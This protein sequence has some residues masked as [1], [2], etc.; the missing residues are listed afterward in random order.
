MTD[1]SGHQSSVSY[2]DSFSDSLNRNTFAYPTTITDA[3][4]FS[5]TVQYNF[6]FGAIT[7]TQSPAPAGQSQGAIQTM[8]YNSL[9]QLERLTTTNN[10]AYKRF[11]Y[12]ADFVGSYTSVNNVADELYALEVFDGHGRVI[13]AAGNHPG[14]TGGY[15]LVSTIY[16]HL[17]RVKKQSNPTE[18]NSS[19]V[20]SGDDAAGMY[21]TQQTY[22]WQGRPLVTT[23]Q[24]G[25]TKT[26][27][28]SGCG[29]AGGA[30]VTLT[31]E[32]TLDA[33]VVKRR[34]QKIFS[35]V[36]GR[37]VK[38]EILTWQGGSVYSATVNTYN[39]RDQ[40][41]QMRQ[42]AGAEGSG[43]Y[44]D[45]TMTYDG[46]GRLKTK[47][48]PEQNAG[49]NT[50][51]TYNPDDTINTVTDA[52]GAVATYGHNARHLVTAITYSAPAGIT[53]TANVTFSY[54]AAGNRT[55]MTE[56]VGSVTYSH[57]QLSQLTSETR[58]ITGVGN[59]TLNYTYNLIGQLRTI[60]DPFG[61]QVGYSH[62]KVG[63][64]SA[65]TGANFA[66]VT[67]YASNL[68]YRAWGAL[69]SLTYG[70]SK[71]LAVGYYQN[72]NVSTYEIPG[73]MKKAYQYYDDGRLKFTQDQF[74]TNSKFDRLYNYDH[75]GRITTALSGAE[76]RGQ[77]PTNDRPYNQTMAY[78]ALGHL[79]LREI[80]HWDRW[81]SSGNQTYVNNR[82]Q[83]WQYDADGRLLN[84]ESQYTYDA[85]GR[86]SSFGDDDP[87]RTDQQLDGDGRRLK[88][89]QRSFDPNTNQWTIEKV[90]Y[91]IYSSV[92]GSVISE[93]SAAGAKER[94]FVSAG[95]QV[96]A[97]QSVVGGT[98][99][100]SWEHYDASNA[101]YRPTNP[102]GGVGL[103]KEM[104]PIGANA[105]TMKPI[106]WPEPTSSGKLEP[107][108][109]IPELNSA[110][111][112]CEV[113]GVPMDC[114]DAAHLE[115][116]GA[117]KATVVNPIDPSRGGRLRP[118]W[119]RKDTSYATTDLETNTVT[120][121]SGSGGEFVWVEELGAGLE[122]FVQK[123]QRQK[124][125][126]VWFVPLGDLR[127]GLG[128]LLKKKDCAD[129]VQKLLNEAKRLFGGNY[130]SINNIW[131]GF[132][133]ISS[134]GGYQLDGVASN[135]GTVTGD[136]FANGALS[137]T[138]HIT[139]YRTIDRV[140]RAQEISWAQARYA[141]TALHETFHLARQGGYTDEQMTR[142]AYSLAGKDPPN[143]DRDGVLSWS[144]SFDDF[145]AQH[146]PNDTT[147]K[148]R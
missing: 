86:I 124:K 59:F 54:D 125:P 79:T 26:A 71:T 132:D 47:H 99:Y 49:A 118:E 110:Y 129:Y 112:G 10:S 19:W 142:A 133:K 96:L 146:C 77:G 42:Y 40:V 92:L 14:S 73:V 50:V 51:F 109:G 43:T 34:Q 57:N 148:K 121:Y 44:Q 48:V 16:D 13:G 2:A 85:A 140:P 39:V 139:P 78:D 130:D 67:S 128:D 63:R 97:I 120:I 4:G 127:K 56:G 31:D 134:A 28:Y 29:C 18:V 35:D 75:V 1:P 65:V 61:A 111:D 138:V 12:G 64:L 89:V 106:T 52:R 55:S 115:K 25:T 32:G 141:Y 83:F 6:D 95:D 11:W 87:Y 33:G 7:R 53:P 17:G 5:S 36:F 104:D 88:S 9:G 82:R 62:D 15:R 27:A 8:T 93:V 22:D 68:Q 136:L 101:S 126:A 21:Y 41:T 37:T 135:G 98:Q 30:V 81:D 72:L 144:G 119:A 145:L 103:A 74:T 113:N 137:G 90:T 84:G 45:T 24:D 100:V 80:R 20:P 123:R 108:Y 143:Y 58:A 116:I 69:K 3:G 114:N 131:E 117:G 91:Y 76:A 147:P 94:S 60:T 38:T 105:G 107:Y 66:S 46:Y 122:T 70:N 23:N 102:Q